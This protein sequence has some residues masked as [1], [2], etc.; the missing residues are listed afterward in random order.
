M[1]WLDRRRWWAREGLPA[2]RILAIEHWDPE[3]VYD[4]P[5]HADA[6]D[7]YLERLGR[8]LRRGKSVD[9]LAAYLSEVRT[10]AFRR[11]PNEESDRAFAERVAA[12]Y[13]LEAPTG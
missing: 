8:M 3:G 2:L 6:Y 1:A 10:R 7:P 11:Y 5:L 12:W 4:D 9:E 13:S